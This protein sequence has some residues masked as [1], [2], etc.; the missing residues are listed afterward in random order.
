MTKVQGKG[1]VIDTK[2]LLVQDGDFYPRDDESGAGRCAGGG[3][4]ASQSWWKL[5]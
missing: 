5:V 3:E 1:E 2:A 4:V